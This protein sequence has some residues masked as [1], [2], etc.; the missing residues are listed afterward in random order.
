MAA[1]PN[2]PRVVPEPVEESDHDSALVALPPVPPPPTGLPPI[3]SQPPRYDR[4]GGLLAN[5]K[6]LE[7]IDQDHDVGRKFQ[8]GRFVKKASNAIAREGHYEALATMAGV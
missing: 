8:R 2:R 4:L 6:D 5:K 7:N 3:K 1:N